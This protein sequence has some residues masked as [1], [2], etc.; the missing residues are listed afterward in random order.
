MVTARSSWRVVRARSAAGPL[1]HVVALAVLLFGILMAHG[2]HVDGDRDHLPI[3]TTANA[4]LPADGPRAAI[5]EPVSSFA[6]EHECRHGGHEPWH[7]GEQCFPGQP[8]Q[9][10][11]LASPC[12]AAPVRAST[13]ADPASTLRGPAAGRTIDQAYPPAPRAASVVRQV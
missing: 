10:S 2:V 13:S 1:P 7:P 9:G 6:T 3:S 12:C 8:Q 5:L 11:A 4:A